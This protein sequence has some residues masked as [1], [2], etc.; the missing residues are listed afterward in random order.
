MLG[1]YNDI[2]QLEFGLV[3][4]TFSCSK[5]ICKQ[6]H[7]SGQVTEHTNHYAQTLVSPRLHNPYP[8]DHDLATV[9]PFSSSE[10]QFPHCHCPRHVKDGHILL[11]CRC[12]SRIWS[13]FTI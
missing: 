9:S 7:T 11:C 6:L 13:S 8:V 10:R 12:L 2:D 4:S 3:Y 5:L 1:L